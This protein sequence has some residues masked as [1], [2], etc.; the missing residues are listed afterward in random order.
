MGGEVDGF[1]D[2]G[3]GGGPHVKDLVE[4]EAE[5]GEGL[6]V[7]GPVAELSDDEI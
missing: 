4:T 5:E 1:V 7:G 2:G 6:G 3:V